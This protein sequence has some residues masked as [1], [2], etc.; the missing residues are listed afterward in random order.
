MSKF[1]SV[2]LASLIL[3]S[4]QA[5]AVANDQEILKRVAKDKEVY[6]AG[7]SITENYSP[8]NAL[9]YWETILKAEPNNAY[10][11]EIKKKIEK[12]KADNP[13]LSKNAATSSSK[14]VDDNSKKPP[15]IGAG[16]VRIG[17][18]T[19]FSYSNM[20][21][22]SYDSH[23]IA[24]GLDADY[25]VLDF[26]TL[27]FD[28]GFIYTKIGSDDTKNLLVGPAIG[29]SVVIANT[30]IPFLKIIPGFGLLDMGYGTTFKKF[31]LGIT[32]GID[33][34]VSKNIAFGLALRYDRFFTETAIN[35]ITVPLRFTFYL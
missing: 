32:G 30:V 22:G 31:N 25:F 3:L 20:S 13:K 1:F 14:K 26:L 29:T 12:I 16:S 24:F 35:Q 18:N 15:S 19:G 27:G 10:A 5:Q 33:V 9:A 34:L 2:I 21:V 8:E 11:S 7:I 28:L 4:F 17:A 23:S 6:N